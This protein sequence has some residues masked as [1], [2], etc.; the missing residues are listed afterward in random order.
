MFKEEGKRGVVYLVYPFALKVEKR[1]SKA[2]YRIAHEGRWLK[3]V[4]FYGIGPR[5]YF[6]GKKFLLMQY[7]RGERIL[8]FFKHA[9]LEEK[10]LVILE[11][12]RQ[13]SVLDKLHI[14]KQEMHHPL[15]HILI[16]KK[17]ILIDFERCKFSEKPKNVTQFAQFLSQLGFELPRKDFE[18]FLKEYKKSYREEDYMRIRD[19]IRRF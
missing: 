9:S 15:K 13:C 14:D 16:G 2:M 7:V 4:N 8:D 5:L 10:K 18:R 12:F 17:I 1:G 11:V 19:L 3:K 6:P